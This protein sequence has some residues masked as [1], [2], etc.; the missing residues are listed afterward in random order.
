MVLRQAI[1]KYVALFFILLVSDATSWRAFAEPVRLMVLGDSLSAGYGLGPGE[2]FPDQLVARLK[3][4]GHDLTLINAS[5]SGDTTAGGRARLDWSLADRPDAVILALGGNDVL[6]GLEPAAARANLAAMLASLTSR[7]LP[8][9]LCGMQ[10]PRNLGP[11]YAAEFDPIYPELAAE[12]D[13]L[14]YPFLLDGVAL[15]PALNQ[16]DGMHPNKA[17]VAVMVGRVLPFAEQLLE[18]IKQ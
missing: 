2:S 17:G 14:L 18:Q 5:I 9:L 13:V 16:L 7:G 15:D 4:R 6:R 8:V 11:D 1:F 3:D 12:Y 10:A